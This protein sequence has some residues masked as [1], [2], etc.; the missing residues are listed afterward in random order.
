MIQITFFFVYFYRPAFAPIYTNQY[1]H[2]PISGGG[3]SGTNQWSNSGTHHYS[4]SQYISGQSSSTKRDLD[5]LSGG[6]GSSRK[7]KRQYKKRKHKSQ[8][9]KQSQYASPN[10]TTPLEMVQSSEDEEL[11]TN[12]INNVPGSEGEDEGLFPF[13][14]NVNCQYHKVNSCLLLIILM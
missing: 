7:E 2:S 9:E 13:R 3:T 4:T 8:R 5:V 14:R 6:T 12:N 10:P 1:S 11:T